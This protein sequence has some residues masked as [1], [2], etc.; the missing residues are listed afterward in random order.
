VSKQYA[1]VRLENDDVQCVSVVERD[2]LFFAECGAAHGVA[3]T[4]RGAVVN[5]ASQAPWQGGEGWPI[6]EILERGEASRIEL[7]RQLDV[8]RADVARLAIVRNEGAYSRILDARGAF[9]TAV[10]ARVAKARSLRA[11]A[12]YGPLRMVGEDGD[13]AIVDRIDAEVGTGCDR[14]TATFFA[15]CGEIV[16]A[17]CNDVQQAMALLDVSAD[18]VDTVESRRLT[19]VSEYCAL[20]SHA[21]DAYLQGVRAAIARVA[22][23]APTP[24]ARTVRSLEFVAPSEQPEHPAWLELMKSEAY[25]QTEELKALREEVARLTAVNTELAGGVQGVCDEQRTHSPTPRGAAS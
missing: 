23:I 3:S 10:D 12:A 9:A 5:L 14:G 11:E 18:L 21:D 19:Y 22:A 15:S 4:V 1:L 24:F 25:R 7:L 8:S 13:Y 2:G 16:E 6:V 17:L 20:A